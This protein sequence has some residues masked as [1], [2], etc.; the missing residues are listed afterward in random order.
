MKPWID[1]NIS[2]WCPPPKAS[3]LWNGNYKKHQRCHRLLSGDKIPT[4]IDVVVLTSADTSMTRLPVQ[5]RLKPPEKSGGAG[6]GRNKGNG[7]IRARRAIEQEGKGSG[8]AL[9]ACNRR[10]PW[11]RPGLGLHLCRRETAVVKTW[12]TTFS[13]TVEGTD[14]IFLDHSA[15]PGWRMERVA[16]CLPGWGKWNQLTGIKQE[17][18][19]AGNCGIIWRQGEE[20]KAAKSTDGVSVNMMIWR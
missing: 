7:Q 10:K 1:V 5:I 17:D 16:E 9:E 20:E 2:D 11:A 15:L 12:P 8:W 14:R 18:S 19:P 4:V 13:A 3:M 6:F